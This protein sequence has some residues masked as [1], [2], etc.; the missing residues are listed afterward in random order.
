MSVSPQPSLVRVFIGLLSLL[1][2]QVRVTAQ[3]TDPNR[4]PRS[5][6]SRAPELTADL[7]LHGGFVWTVDET[8]PIAEAI[9]VRNGRILALGPDAEILLRQEPD[10]RVI[11]L[12][13]AFLLPGFNDNHIHF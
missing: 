2:I 10:T 12:E 9:A 11:D 5:S 13:G 8:N 3:P 4:D 6:E 1:L 7:I